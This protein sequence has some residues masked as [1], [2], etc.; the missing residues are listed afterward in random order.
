MVDSIRRTGRI[1]V[2]APAGQL[3]PVERRQE[4][5][6]ERHHQGGDESPSTP[7]ESKRSHADNQEGAATSE[8]AENSSGNE[9]K[10]TTGRCIDVRI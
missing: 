6:K 5:Y 10:L 8:E 1:G 3:R 7:E 2:I 9:R 4:S